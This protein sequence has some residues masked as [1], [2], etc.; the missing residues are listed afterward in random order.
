MPARDRQPFLGRGVWLTAA[1][2]LLGSCAGGGLLLRKPLRSL[3][4]GYRHADAV[5]GLVNAARRGPLSDADFAQAL[6]YT[7]A[8][9]PPTRYAAMAALQLEAERD[10]ARRPAVV[11]RL[12]A[13]TA[14]PDVGP[15][16]ATILGRLTAPEAAR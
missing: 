14:D 2:V 3:A 16:A 9:H 13:L 12:A 15:T 4:Y 5:L 8:P 10:P 7:D 6:A 11:E 1:V